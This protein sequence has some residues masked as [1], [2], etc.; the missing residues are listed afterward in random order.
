MSTVNPRGLRHNLEQKASAMRAAADTRPHGEDWREHIEAICRADD[1][2]GVRK[3]DVGGWKLLSDSGPSFG[4]WGL[5]PSSPE[6]LCAVVSTCLTHTYLIGAATLGIPVDTVEVRV[7]A[8]NNDA[9]F[10]GV[11]TSDPPLPFNLVATVYLDAADA[12]DEQRDALHE[13]A[14]T[15]CPLTML[16]REPQSIEIRVEGQSAGR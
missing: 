6:L 8:D 13:Y 9:R 14:R 11:E 16:L 10:V 15:R 5:G 3:V 2:S 7:S 12:T 4:G 1:A